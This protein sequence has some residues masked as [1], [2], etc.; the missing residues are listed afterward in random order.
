V[1][2]VVPEIPGVAE[3]QS[4]HRAADSLNVR[5]RAWYL[6]PIGAAIATAVYFLTGHPSGLFNLIGLSSPVLIVVGVRMHRPPQRAPWYFFALGQFLFI[7]GDVIAYN[8]DRIFHT[9]LPYPAISDLFYLLV[10]PCL[11]I[12]LLLIVRRRMPGRDWAGFIDS[13]MVAIGVG[14]VSWL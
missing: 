10:Y 4:A 13:L 14:T 7:C 12:G 1:P 6:Y 5:N 3:L 11:A 8:Y 2:F 9:E